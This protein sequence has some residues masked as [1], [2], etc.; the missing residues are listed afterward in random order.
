MTKKQAVMLKDDW[1]KHLEE[2]DFKTT[3]YLSIKNNGARML[4]N[5]CFH[6]QENY[7]FIWTRSSSFIINKKDIGEFLIVTDPTKPLLSK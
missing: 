2:N 4:K 6:E 1:G 7:I 3:L 5:C